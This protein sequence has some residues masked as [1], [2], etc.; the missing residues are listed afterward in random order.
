MLMDLCR[1]FGRP[2]R[3]LLL[4]ALALCVIG[5]GLL[6][7]PSTVTAFG[8]GLFLLTVFGGVAGVVCLTAFQLMSPRAHG[9]ANAIFFAT[10]TVMGLGLGP[11]V[12]GLLSDLVFGPLALGKA[13]FCTAA[14]MALCASALT[15]G[16]RNAYQR[17]TEAAEAARRS[18]PSDQCASRHG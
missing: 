8:V 2:P 9:S 11:P 13:L 3:Q 4:V 1:R 7:A 16:S 12:I 5:A 6:W 14:A 18:A 17:V 10:I 15:V